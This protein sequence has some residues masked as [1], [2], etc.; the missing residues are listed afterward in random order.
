MQQLTG[1]FDTFLQLLTTQLQNQDPMNPMDSNQFTQQLVEFSQ[2]EQQINTNSNLQNLIG[3]TEGNAGSAAVGYL[4][5]NVTITNG[6]GALINSDCQW[7][8]NLPSTPSSVTLTVTNSSGQTVY[9]D[10]INSATSGNNTF[11]W[12]GQESDG[13]TAPDGTYTLSVSAT[14]AGGSSITPSISYTGAVSE[15]SFQNG[16]PVLMIGTMAVPLSQVS[17]IT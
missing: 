13:S 6:N 7:T 14:G 11:D 1:N 9:T 12:K 10:T 2:V 17:S 15:I 5:K 4:G 16:V 3:L 8:Y